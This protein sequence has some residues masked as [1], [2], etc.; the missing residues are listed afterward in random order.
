MNQSETSASHYRQ[1]RENACEQVT[2]GFGFIYLIGSESGVRNFN[3]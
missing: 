2:I 3:Q 1:A